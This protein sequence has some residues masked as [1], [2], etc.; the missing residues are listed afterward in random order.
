MRHG[1]A[2]DRSVLL[3]LSA[4]SGTGKTTLARRLCDTFRPSLFSVSFTTRAIRGREQDGVDYHFVGEAR[5]REMVQADQFVEWAEVHGHFYGTPREPVERVA[6]QG[7]LVLFDIDVQGGEQVK[8]RYPDAVTVLVLPPSY[9]ELERRL[10]ARGT[11]TDAV[12]ERRL[13]AAQAEI[14][15]ARSYD[16]CLVN[17]DLEQAFRELASIVTAERLRGRRYDLPALGY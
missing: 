2:A 4:P 13:L 7:G 14:R 12:I 1:P 8:A 16:Y 17:D 9:A 11:D 5:F 3:V 10:R 15:R 6:A